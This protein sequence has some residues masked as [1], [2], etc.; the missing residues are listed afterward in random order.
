MIA[1]VEKRIDKSNRALKELKTRIGNNADVTKA[2]LE[3]VIK[4]VNN[5]TKPNIED[6]RAVYNHYANQNI[7]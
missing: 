6:L 2:F 1:S 3:D 7:K 5:I 4:D